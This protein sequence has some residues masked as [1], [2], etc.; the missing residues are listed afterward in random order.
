MGSSDVDIKEVQMLRSYTQKFDDFG[1]S[2]ISNLRQVEGDLDEMLNEM[3]AMVRDIDSQ[4]DIV[5]E[6]IS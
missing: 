4:M 2:L 5:E 3:E 1:N 6:R